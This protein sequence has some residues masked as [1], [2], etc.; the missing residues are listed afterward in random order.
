MSFFCLSGVI[1]LVSGHGSLV[2]PPSRNNYQQKSPTAGGHG[3]SSHTNSG[4]CVG[5]ACLWFSEGC[6]LGCNTCSATMP[7]G[8]NQVDKPNCTDFVPNVPTLPEAFRTYNK[9][10]QSVNGD[11]TRYHPWRSPGEFLFSPVAEIDVLCVMSKLHN[12]SADHSLHISR[13]SV[14][15]QSSGV[16]SL[17]HCWRIHS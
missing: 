14:C 16:R 10:N 9:L 17:R 7:A 2:I 15:R 13:S 12:L 11:W 5:G 3:S 8:G 1:G 6:F 4:P